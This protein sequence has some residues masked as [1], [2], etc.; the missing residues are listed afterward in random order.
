MNEQWLHALAERV[1][2][3]LLEQRALLTDGQT[4]FYVWPRQDRAVIVFD[5]AVI[6]LRRV[7]ERLA[8]YLSTRLQ[9]RR[10]VQTN[11]RGLY[12][13]VGYEIPPALMEMNEKPLDLSTQPT[14]VH[15]PIGTTQRGDLWISLLDANSILVGGSRRMGKT[16]LMHGFIQSLLHGNCVELYAWDGKG[17]IE[18]MRYVSQPRFNILPDN[19]Q[20]GLGKLKLIVQERRKRLLESGQ[21]NILEYNEAHPNEPM[22]PI[23]LMIDEAALVPDAMRPALVELVEREG[24]AGIYPILATNRPEQSSLLVKANLVTRISL[25]VPSWNASMMVL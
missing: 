15:I 17:G 5:T 6:D 22:L 21:T 24:A 3:L 16:G 20:A 13:Q 23:C 14:P 19:L 18:F 2:A 25:S 8:H 7:N 10:V 11:H 12:W 9:G 1:E 4:A